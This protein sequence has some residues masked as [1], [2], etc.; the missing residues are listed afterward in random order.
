VAVQRRFRSCKRA[1]AARLPASRRS[2]RDVVAPPSREG[3]ARAV[4]DLPALAV[5]AVRGGTSVEVK[6][7]ARVRW[8]GRR[9]A[10]AQIGPSAIK[11]HRH[12]LFYLTVQ[13]WS[14][15]AARTGRV[16]IQSDGAKQIAGSAPRR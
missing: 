6:L 10:R 12:Q 11:A 9:P 1:A 13:R 5:T 16:E 2:R 4:Q 14:S 3:G 7:I 8:K 15:I